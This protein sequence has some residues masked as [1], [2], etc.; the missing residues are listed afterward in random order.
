MNTPDRN[1]IPKGKTPDP[2]VFPQWQEY[3]L[4]NGLTVVILEDHTF[5]TINFRLMVPAGGIRDF[6]IPGLT[7]LTAELISRGTVILEGSALAA[8]IESY[9]GRFFSGCQWDASF[10]FI[11]SLSRYQ[12]RALELLAESIRQPGFREKEVSFIA[13]QRLNN[14]KMNRDSTSWLAGYVSNKVLFP[15]HPFENPIN[16]T[17][18]SLTKISPGTVRNHFS[19]WFQPTG[20]L[21][22]VMGDTH[23]DKI[24]PQIE[25]HFASWC[26]E[27]WEPHQIPPLPLIRHNQVVIADKPDAVQSSIRV[28][29]HGI[30]RKNPDLPAIIV[31]NTLLGGY[32]GSRLNLNLREE[33]GFTYG[34]RSAFSERLFAGFFTV[35]T[36]VRNSVTGEAIREIVHEMK[37]MQTHLPDSKV[38]SNVRNFLVGRFPSDFETNEQ[39]SQAIMDL[40]LYGFDEQYFTRLR[41]QISRITADQVLDA[42]RKYLNPDQACIIVAG[43]A[44]DIEGQL[45]EFGNP[46]QYDLTGI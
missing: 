44:D 40:K 11:S 3:T 8:E 27:P 14:L 35:A 5:P 12:S 41:N 7:S 37:Y 32:F 31:M 18:E 34:V 24:L 4:I 1:Q 28:T 38:L 33:K 39:L 16:G 15:G 6:G 29:H 20:S 10:V 21:L 45:T 2:F 46:V 36:D 43:K 42:A 25:T 23:P 9:G 13:D 30:S 22:I 19:R 26:P 17:S